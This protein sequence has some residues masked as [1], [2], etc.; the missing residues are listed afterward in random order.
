MATSMSIRIGGRHGNAT[1]S[2][3]QVPGGSWEV[4][5]VT[6][7]RPKYTSSPL[8]SLDVAAAYVTEQI[9]A[10]EIVRKALGLDPLFVPS[11]EKPSRVS[12]T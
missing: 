3:D 5:L 12:S 4:T 2:I 10:Q 11:P 1:F 6:E 8:P 7:G 9:E